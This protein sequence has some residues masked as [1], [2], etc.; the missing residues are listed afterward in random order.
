MKKSIGP[1]RTKDSAE[2]SLARRNQE[3]DDPA[4]DAIV[5][6]LGCGYAW[7]AGDAGESRDRIGQSSRDAWAV[8]AQVECKMSHPSGSSR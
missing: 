4:G 2:L 6:P 8:T 5:C 7:L 3:R 1:C